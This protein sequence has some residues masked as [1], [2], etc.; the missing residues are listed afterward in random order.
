MEYETEATVLGVGSIADRR[1]NYFSIDTDSGCWEVFFGGFNPPDLSRGE[2]QKIQKTLR[3][4]GVPRS[5]ISFDLDGCLKYIDA[6]RAVLEQLKDIDEEPGRRAFYNIA[7]GHNNRP[8]DRLFREQ[9]MREGHMNLDEAIKNS[10]DS[11]FGG[12]V[13]L[14]ETA[15]SPL[16]GKKVLIISGGPG[17]SITGIKPA[18]G[19]DPTTYFYGRYA[20]M[21]GKFMRLKF[22]N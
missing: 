2:L 10:L 1:K 17:T 20:Q 13:K 4:F 6:E 5:H 12:I 19:Y 14:F 15:A 8:N 3:A 22:E 11:V 7:S 18:P 9:V 21:F 16:V